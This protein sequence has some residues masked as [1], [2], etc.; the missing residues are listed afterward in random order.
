MVTEFRLRAA[1]LLKDLQKE[2]PME[3]LQMWSLCIHQIQYWL[4]YLRLVLKRA[5][6]NPGVE[7]YTYDRQLELWP[8]P[9]AQANNDARVRWTYGLKEVRYSSSSQRL[10]V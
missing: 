7:S 9:Q 6:K 5:I 2:I 4:N 10:M 8:E 3:V 1:S